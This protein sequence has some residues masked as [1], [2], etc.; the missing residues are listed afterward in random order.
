MFPS[1][2]SIGYP[3]LCL[4]PNSGASKNAERPAGG[5]YEST[6]NAPFG[7]N[8]RATFLNAA[9]ASARDVAPSYLHSTR[10]ASLFFF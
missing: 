6:A 9:R 4:N 3:A 5:S 7:R 10:F 8:R 2:S 1:P